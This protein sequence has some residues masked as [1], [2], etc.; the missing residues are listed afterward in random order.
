MA[1]QV[2]QT[3]LLQEDLILLKRQLERVF[4][5]YGLVINE[6]LVVDSPVQI[7]GDQ[8]NYD[9]LAA[10]VLRLTSDA[11]RTVTGVGRGRDGRRLVVINVGGFNITIAH[12]NVGSAAAN[13]VITGTAA[14]V[15]LTPDDYMVLY[16]DHVTLR[17]REIT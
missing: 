3:P 4:N 15:A 6:L 10:G 9:P 1:T 7:T 17:W 13:R 16:Y 2:D 8:D 11:A 12:Q 5:D 14:D